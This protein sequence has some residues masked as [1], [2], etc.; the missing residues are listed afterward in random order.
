MRHFLFTVERLNP[1]DVVSRQHERGG[2]PVAVDGVHEGAGVPG[3]GQTQRMAK[4]MGS[5]QEQVIT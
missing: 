5:H 1:V 4:L 3:V 2:V